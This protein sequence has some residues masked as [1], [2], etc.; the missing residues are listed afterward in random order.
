MKIVTELGTINID[1]FSIVIGAA[2]AVSHP[3]VSRAILQATLK[4]LES[5]D[6]KPKEPTKEKEA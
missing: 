2:V 1:F 3:K 5:M 4:V 6:E